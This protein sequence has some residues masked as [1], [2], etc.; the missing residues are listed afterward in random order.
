MDSEPLL[1]HEGK[2]TTPIP[3]PSEGTYTSQILPSRRQKHQYLPYCF[4]S[5]FTQT[6]GCTITATNPYFPLNKPT[7][8]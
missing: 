2:E 7:F 3:V 4:F 1:H 6:D 5:F 8:Y